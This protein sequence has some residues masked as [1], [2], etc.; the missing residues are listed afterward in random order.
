[1]KAL[2]FRETGSLDRLGVELIETPGIDP[3][4]EA[5]VKVKAAAINPSDPKNVLG[6]ISGTRTPRVP[7]RDFSGIV[8]QGP[9]GWLGKEV[10]GS[11]GTL[12]IDRHGSHAEYVSVPLEGLV[13]KPGEVS[14]EAASTVGVAYLAAWTGMVTSG[15]VSGEDTV[16]VLGA[17]GAVGSTAV[18]IARHFQAKRVIGA[19]R[20]TADEARTAGIPA[21][22]WLNLEKAPLPQGLLDLTSGRGADLILDV[23]GG[24]SFEPITRGLAHRGRHVVIASFEP[25][26]SFNLVDFYHREARLIGVD[27][28]KLSFSESRAILAE[29]L[30]LVRKGVLSAPDLEA[31]RLE[32]ALG[33][34]KRVLE[35]T[36]PRKQVI[37]F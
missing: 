18:K 26:V 6:K 23:V 10:L 27:T 31:I 37:R 15:R 4:R 20:N 16:F 2:Y 21:D 35:G 14:F 34:Y 28:G 17:T 3:G 25:R 9:A 22:Q 8:V 32:E 30:P 5:L 7:G 1:M 19:I 36:A 29:I 12:G 33:A 24:S 13:E 11:G